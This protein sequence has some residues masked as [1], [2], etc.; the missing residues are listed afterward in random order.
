MQYETQDDSL[1]SSAT[2]LNRVSFVTTSH[3]N[4]SGQ[5]LLCSDAHILSFFPVHN[6]IT[7]RGKGNGNGKDGKVWTLEMDKRLVLAHGKGPLCSTEGGQYL[8]KLG[9]Y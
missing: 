8:D 7:K 1:I 3:T 2:S 9:V 6:T 5:I 4:T